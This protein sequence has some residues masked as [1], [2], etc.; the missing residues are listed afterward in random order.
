[1][2]F[3]FPKINAPITNGT[4]PPWKT[5]RKFA[6]KKAKSM[7]RKKPNSGTAVQGLIFQKFLA[8]MNARIVVSTIVSDTAIPYAD[9]RFEED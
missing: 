3:L 9:A 8:T 4:Y 1:L 6:E 2:V 5:L 7:I